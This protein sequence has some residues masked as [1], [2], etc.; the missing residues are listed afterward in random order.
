MAKR[1]RACDLSSRAFVVCGGESVTTF[2]SATPLKQQITLALC[3][4]RRAR[5][6]G[7]PAAIHVAA[8]NLRRKLELLPTPARTLAETDPELDA[9][10]RV[11][12][13]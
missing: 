4:L 9:W 8:E 1:A 7:D 12:W 3:L 13:K 5:R 11:T 6:D 2:A 10:L